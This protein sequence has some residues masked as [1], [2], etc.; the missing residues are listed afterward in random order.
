MNHGQLFLSNGAHSLADDLRIRF[1]TTIHTSSPDISMSR[2]AKRGDCSLHFG[3]MEVHLI[4]LEDEWFHIVLNLY[5]R[6][7]RLG[8]HGGS[9]GNDQTVGGMCI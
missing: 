6:L 7:W 4:C 3:T 9:Y 8:R 1:P 5:C 2:V